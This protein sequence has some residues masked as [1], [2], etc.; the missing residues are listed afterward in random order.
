MYLFTKA[1][2]KSI[3]LLVDEALNWGRPARSRSGERLAFSLNKINKSSVP[4]K[5]LRTTCRGKYFRAHFRA[6]LYFEAS[7]AGYYASMFSPDIKAVLNKL[8]QPFAG[9]NFILSFKS[10]VILS[11]KYGFPQIKLWME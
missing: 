4:G 9:V 11:T 5:S 2:L 7:R 1:S 6:E 3:R 10:G 8:T